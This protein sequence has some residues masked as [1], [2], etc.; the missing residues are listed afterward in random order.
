M[1]KHRRFLTFFQCSR[2]PDVEKFLVQKAIQFEQAS[3]ASTHLILNENG[4]ILAYYALSFKEIRIEASK[5][6]WKKLSGGLGA[7][8]I[9]KVFLIV[10]ISKNEAI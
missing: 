8:N 10:Q 9:L 3:A 5:T 2:N 7:G 4:Q 1:K 6:L